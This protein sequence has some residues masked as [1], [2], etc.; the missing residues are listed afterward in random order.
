MSKAAALT[1]KQICAG[2]NISHVTAYNW[3]KGTATQQPLPVIDPEARDVRFG[4]GATQA[5]AKAHGRAFSK[6]AA[7]RAADAKA[8]PAQ[9]K[10]EKKA[11]KAATAPTKAA[12]KPVLMDKITVR[13]SRV[14]SSVVEA[15]KRK[16][17][18]H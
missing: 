18:A 4:L 9:A 16:K 5:W 14:T 15:K 11:T 7:L 6:E 8:S 1:T 3:R 13:G 17:V 2:F 12:K 10:A